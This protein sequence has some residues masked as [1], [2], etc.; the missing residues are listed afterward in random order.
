MSQ[1]GAHIAISLTSSLLKVN[2]TK[3]KKSSKSRFVHDYFNMK[4]LAGQ[5]FIPADL[6]IS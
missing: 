2:L 3:T 4:A 5:R 6:L 1:Y